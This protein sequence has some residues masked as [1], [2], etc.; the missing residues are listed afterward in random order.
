MRGSLGVRALGIFDDQMEMEIFDTSVDAF[1][2]L[3]VHTLIH[4]PLNCD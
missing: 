4:G 2:F 1:G 3:H